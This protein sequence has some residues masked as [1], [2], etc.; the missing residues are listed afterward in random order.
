MATGR[1]R[2]TRICGGQN[3]SSAIGIDLLNQATATYPALTKT[4]DDAGFKVKTVE[5]GATVGVGVDVVVT[6]DP[7]VKG[8]KRT[9]IQE[10]LQSIL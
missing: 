3:G 2:S 5:H 7:Q 1:R 4:W 6:K 10:W 9:G 8:F